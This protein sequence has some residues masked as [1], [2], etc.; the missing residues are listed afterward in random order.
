MKKLFL[1]AAMGTI[2]SACGAYT[3]VTDYSDCL[4]KTEVEFNLPQLSYVVDPEQQFSVI[5]LPDG[6]YFLCSGCKNS[7]KTNYQ[8]IAV[9]E[10]PPY[11]STGRMKTI[12]EKGSS[13][14]YQV[15]VG[16]R[17][18]WASYY[19]FTAQTVDKLGIVESYKAFSCPQK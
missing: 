15:K 3:E 9:S 7:A 13:R 17:Y 4:T 10:P 5:D 8:V 18:L 19:D 6:E 16:E 1:L 11:Y 14:I 2:L 12:G